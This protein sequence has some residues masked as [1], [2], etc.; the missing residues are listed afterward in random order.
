LTAGA[1]KTD[2]GKSKAV[3]TPSASVF[4]RAWNACSAKDVNEA[5]AKQF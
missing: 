3:W 1:A 2:T 4:D 5:D